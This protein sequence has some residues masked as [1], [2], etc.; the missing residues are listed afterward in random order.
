MVT[1]IN[2]QLPRG[3]QAPQRQ[4]YKDWVNKITTNPKYFSK[5]LEYFDLKD[6]NLNFR[7]DQDGEVIGNI[8]IFNYQLKPKWNIA[9][10]FTSE[11]WQHE[12]EHV[13]LEFQR[14]PLAGDRHM[15]DES[16]LI[17]FEDT[18]TFI[19]RTYR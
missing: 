10:D 6:V 3:M 12:L 7:D 15:G 2:F 1:K 9:E 11:Y 13:K 16:Q 8:H 18:F 4:V 14:S 19:L 17:I 5:V